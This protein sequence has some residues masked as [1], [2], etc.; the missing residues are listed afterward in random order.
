MRNALRSHYNQT[1]KPLATGYFA[2]KPVGEVAYF[3]SATGF[4]DVPHDHD[5][6]SWVP[7]TTASLRDA[8]A[9]LIPPT[10]DLGIAI[11]R[12]R[13]KSHQVRYKLEK[14]SNTQIDII[15]VR[16]KGEVIDLYDFNYEGPTPAP[17]AAALQIGFGNGNYGQGR[18]TRGKIYRDRIL[19]DVS[20][21]LIY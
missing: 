1:V 6:P 21:P 12:A 11:G 14:M 9:P 15:Q 10:D 19:F 17:Y 20:W 13:I 2:S 5:S 4:Y 8:E 3:P 7:R 18:D 16:H